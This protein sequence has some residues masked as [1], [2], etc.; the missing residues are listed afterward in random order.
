MYESRSCEVKTLLSGCGDG[1]GFGY[2]RMAIG[3]AKVFHHPYYTLFICVLWDKM[4]ESL[5]E[6]AASNVLSLPR[7]EKER[8]GAK[9]VYG[10][11]LM[12][13]FSSFSSSDS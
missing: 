10:A 9:G 13:V 2:E 12:F 6:L 5:T 4:N 11:A 7:R 3:A 1:G 8:V